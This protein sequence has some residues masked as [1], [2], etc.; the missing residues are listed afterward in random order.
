MEKVL[1]RGKVL[2]TWGLWGRRLLNARSWAD[3]GRC[4]RTLLMDA[5]ASGVAR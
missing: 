3:W 2:G 1:G 4:G 5:R